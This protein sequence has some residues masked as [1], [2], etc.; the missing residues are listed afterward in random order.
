MGPIVF[1]FH[2]IVCSLRTVHRNGFLQAIDPKA[3]ISCPSC[4]AE[5]ETHDHIIQCPDP[6]RRAI[7][8]DFTTSLRQQCEKSKVNNQLTETFLGNLTAW[9]EQ[10]KVPETNNNDTPLCRAVTEQ[11][12]IGW[13]KCMQGFISTKFQQL[14]NHDKE[15]LL[16]KFESVKLTTQVI[17]LVWQHELN[18][19]KARND[20]VHGI[21]KEEKYQIVRER[22]LE[23]EAELYSLKLDIPE[24][25]SS[26][27]FKNW[28]RIIKT[29]NRPL[30]L[31]LQITQRTVHYLLDTSKLPNDDPNNDVTETIPSTVPT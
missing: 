14:I 8:E 19:W 10:T 29:R 15:N 21:T 1:D 18:Q 30:K 12:A 16:S 9:V 20:D 23:D 4:G 3:K 17:I 5:E 11:N 27:I 31:W 25:D 2:L 22:L 13:N 6:K 28:Y 26:K 24:P 7:F